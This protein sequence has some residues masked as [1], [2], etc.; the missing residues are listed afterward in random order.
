MAVLEIRD[1][2]KGIPS[3]ILEESGEDWLGA[4]GVGLRGMKE[5]MRQLGGSL[6]ISSGRDGTR[7]TA[8]IPPG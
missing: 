7:V 8:A 1:Q 2:G 4:I 3:A 6:E 5:R